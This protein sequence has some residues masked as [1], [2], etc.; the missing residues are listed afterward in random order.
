MGKE[1]NNITVLATRA[2]LRLNKTNNRFGYKIRLRLLRL[3]MKT[4]SPF[5]VKPQ[6]AAA[7]IRRTFD[8][9]KQVTL[10]TV[11]QERGGREN[12]PVSR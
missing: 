5:G 3:F 10:M 12:S 9:R 2:V 11:D 4:L 6:R 7:C 8:A 1:N